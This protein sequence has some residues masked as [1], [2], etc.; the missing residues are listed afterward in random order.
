[1]P[2]C[3]TCGRPSAPRIRELRR[4]L[5]I[6]QEELASRANLHWT[7][8]SDRERGRQT[9]TLDLLNRLARAMGVTFAE[10]FAPL[11]EPYRVRFRKPR[12]TS[13]DEPCSPIVP[14]A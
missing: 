1:M 6:S 11:N 14:F 4:R 13:S 9:P 2:A 12:R 8:L 7:Y 10:F 5:E 3:T